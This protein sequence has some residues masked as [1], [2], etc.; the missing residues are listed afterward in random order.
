MFQPLYDYILLK[1]DTNPVEI[2]GYR[3]AKT[4]DTEAAVATV[5]AVGPGTLTEYGDLVQVVVCEGDTV[6][7]NRYGGTEY[8]DDDGE[9]Y[10]I[11]R[12]K[13]LMGIKHS[14]PANEL[15]NIDTLD[16]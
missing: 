8:K 9:D 4:G 13:D 14:A 2:G 3:V 7:F 12:A 10:I 15:A 6:V 11:L 1:E 5:V 16:F